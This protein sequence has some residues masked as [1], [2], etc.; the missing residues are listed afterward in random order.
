MLS[1]RIWEQ[2]SLMSAGHLL[3]I[4]LQA[5]GQGHVHDPPDPLGVHPHAKGH[6]SH[7][8]LDLASTKG[9]LDLLSI[10]QVLPCLNF[11]LLCISIMITTVLSS[12][13]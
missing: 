11:G 5:P 6:R 7:H 8:N 1:E 3:D 10:L 9:Q 2:K 4:L 12:S 13:W